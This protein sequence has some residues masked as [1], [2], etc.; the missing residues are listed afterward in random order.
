MSQ[1][2]TT[3]DARIEAVRAM[4]GW[5]DASMIDLL[6]RYIRSHDDSG[7]ADNLAEWLELQAD[8][9]NRAFLPSG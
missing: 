3:A 4:Q 5:N 8:H 6:T 7:T 1:D 2:E 9:E